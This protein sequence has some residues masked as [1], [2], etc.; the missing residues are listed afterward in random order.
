MHLRLHNVAYL[1]W[2]A[3]EL[4][5]NTDNSG[6]KIKIRLPRYHFLVWGVAAVL[7]LILGVNKSIYGFWGIDPD[8]KTTFCWIDSDPSEVRTKVMDTAILTDVGL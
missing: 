5:F 6:L 4:T 8:L 3:Y 1:L 2:S 7:T